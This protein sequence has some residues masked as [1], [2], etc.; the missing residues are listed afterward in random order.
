[1]VFNKLIVEAID[2]F[3]YEMK[4]EKNRQKV[5]EEILEPL[6]DFILNKIKP[7]VIGTSIFLITIILLIICILYLILTSG[8]KPK[9][10]TII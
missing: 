1:M 2:I 6:I 9:P 5:E 3:I 8:V 4:K 10:I 7:Y